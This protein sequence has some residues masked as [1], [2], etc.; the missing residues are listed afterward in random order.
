MTFDLWTLGFQAVNVVVLIWLLQ[1]FFWKPVAAMIANRQDSIATQL[2]DAEE[3]RA[4]A[5]EALAGLAASRAGIA[6]EHETMLAAARTEARADGDALLAKARAEADSLHDTAKTAR[7]RAAE[8]LKEVAA[9]DAQA[10]ALTI[11]GQ[12]LARL[13]ASV[14][15]AAFLGWLL[16]GLAALPE[17]DRKALAMSELSVISAVA[18]DRA[19][20]D[21]IAAAITGALGAPARLHFRSDP[22]LIAGLELQSPHFALRNS[23]RADLTR[24]AAA[25]GDQDAVPDAA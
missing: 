8:A 18:T 20:Q 2:E 3:A 1:R 10:L 9:R 12:L 5:K 17:A 16:E 7:V 13:D 6:A 14:T 22:D 24:I 4:E 11:A 23:W 21:R 15:E 19:A 25:L